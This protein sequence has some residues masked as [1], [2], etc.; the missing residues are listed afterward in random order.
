[1]KLSK[2]AQLFTKI[3]ISSIIQPKDQPIHK[4]MLPMYVR[5]NVVIL[6]MNRHC[7][8]E[9]TCRQKKVMELYEEYKGII[10]KKGNTTAINKAKET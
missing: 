5:C 10:T 1:M 8:N 3:Q 4:A 2:S 9:D 7:R 6:K